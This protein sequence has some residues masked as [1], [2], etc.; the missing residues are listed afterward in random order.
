MIRNERQYRTTL[1]QR[2]ALADALDRLLGERTDTVSGERGPF[3]DQAQLRL[4]LEQ[5]SLDG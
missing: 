3:D 5:A 2:Q 1:R 4:E